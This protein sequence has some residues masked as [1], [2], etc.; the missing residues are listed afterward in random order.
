M[1]TGTH[2]PTSNAEFMAGIFGTLPPNLRGF[3]NG[4]EG[5]PDG[6]SWGGWPH[7]PALPPDAPSLNWYFTLAVYWPPQAGEYK[8]KGRYCATVHGVMLDDV[9][10]KVDAARLQGLPPSVLIETSPGNHQAIYLFPEPVGDLSAV[11]A[12]QASLIKAGLCDP[13]AHGPTARWSRMPFAVNGKRSPPWPCRLVEWHPARRFTIA[14]IRAGLA[15]PE[16]EP[17]QHVAT[18]V[19]PSAEWDGM[20]EA[21]QADLVEDLRSALQVIPSDDRGEWVRI[22]HCLAGSLPSNVAY[23]LWAEWSATSAK[24]DDDALEQ[25]WTF[26]PDQAGHRGVFTR[27]NGLGWKNPRRSDPARV[28]TDASPCQPLPKTASAP[29]LQL[30]TPSLT[31]P[32]LRLVR[33]DSITLEPVPWVWSGYLPA[34]MLAILGGAPGCGK[35]TI[36][37]ALGAAISAGSR[38]PDDQPTGPAGDVLVWSGEDLH[39]VLAGRLAAMGADRSRVHF[40]GDVGEGAQKRSFDP[41]HDLPLLASAAQALPA[42]R[43]LIIDPIVSAVA[44]DSHRNAEVRRALQPIVDLAQRLG[45]AVLGITHFTKGTA[46]RDPTE[47]ITGSLA[48]GALARVVLVAA[49]G[50]GEG[51]KARRVF[52]RAKSNI[53]PDDGGFAY[54]LELVEVQPGIEGQRVK[55]LEPIEGAARDI[56]AESEGDGQQD[57][58]PERNADMV[59]FIRMQLV[60]GVVDSKEFQAAAESEGYKWGAVT[61]RA[62]K[63]GAV[64]GKKPGEFS[65]GWIWKISDPLRWSRSLKR[66]PDPT[67]SKSSQSS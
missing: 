4:F 42:L 58:Q 16:P 10:T 21:Q 57:H 31:P 44:G 46:G 55:W 38:W 18:T 3:V 40:V 47:R 27:A 29:V 11:N 8:R 66:A 17:A 56:L 43:L 13:G 19:R 65:A 22:G 24:C 12:L 59:R 60:G 20:T 33:G 25:F 1:N 23:D 67:T 6:G 37:L 32:A 54:E 15:L 52:L 48:F 35:T 50:K 28:F 14:E 64:S 9:G 41:S 2:W 53:G 45:C 7:V 62:K 49:K 63:M 51:D 26:D 61:G 39:S 34:G 5:H 30:P 36:A